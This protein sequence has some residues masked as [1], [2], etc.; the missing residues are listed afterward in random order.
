MESVGSARRRPVLSRDH[1]T[2]AVFV[3]ESGII[4]RDRFFA[5]GL[6]K[7]EEP[8]RL[9]RSIQKFRDQ[10]HWYEEIKFTGV[11][12]RSLALMEQLVD[13]CLDERSGVRFFCFVA[14][15]Q[16]ADPIQRFGS[17]WDAYAKLAEQLLVAALRPDELVSVMA[18]NYSTPDHILFEEDLRAA[19][20]RRVRRLAVV[21]VCRLDSR[22]SDGLQVADL[23]TSAIA[24]EFRSSAG[25]A[26]AM[27]DKAELSS[28]VRRRL[29]AS[30][31]VNGWRNEK[32]SVAV[33]R[34]SAVQPPDPEGP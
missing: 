33:Y 1:P 20:N 30:S 24:F 26:S 15:R 11:R 2:S 4:S 31:C 3:D 27:G 12:G 17:S 22:S 16:Q 6:L 29:G 19:V 28:H 5:V 7:C 13:V 10:K 14:D 34:D 32:H 9:L 21:S 18:D 25:L 8:S 23:F